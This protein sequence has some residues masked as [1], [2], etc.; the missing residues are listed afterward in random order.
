MQWDFL[1]RLPFMPRFYLADFRFALQAGSDGFA[2]FTCVSSFRT[3]SETISAGLKRLHASHFVAVHPANNSRRYCQNRGERHADGA[4]DAQAIPAVHQ[5][6]AYREL[7]FWTG[8]IRATDL[9][10]GEN[11][12]RES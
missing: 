10:S 11:R 3:P 7:N 2:T 9:A 5:R 6:W 1:D 12:D 4:S 8:K